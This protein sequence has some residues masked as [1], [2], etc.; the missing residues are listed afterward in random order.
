MALRVVEMA[1]VAVL[2]S[3][4]WVLAVRPWRRTREVRIEGLLLGLGLR[5]RLLGWWPQLSQTAVLALMW[6]FFF[7]FDF[8]AENLIIRTSEAYSFVRTEE[9]LTL[10]AGEQYQFPLYER[11]P[12]RLRRARR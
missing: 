6:V 2:L 3:A 9:S 8:V 11:L 12:G 7:V 10:W 5:A 1:S 4:I